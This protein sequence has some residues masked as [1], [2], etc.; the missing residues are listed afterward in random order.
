MQQKLFVTG[1]VIIMAKPMEGP[2]NYFVNI[3]ETNWGTVTFLFLKVL[4][5]K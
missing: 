2:Q 5:V 1:P 3:R 4:T